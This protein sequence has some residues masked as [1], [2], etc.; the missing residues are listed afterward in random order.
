[1][2]G[3]VK[4]DNRVVVI[5]GP[6]KKVKVT[7]QQVLEALKIDTDELMPYQDSKRV[8]SLLRNELKPG[9]IIRKETDAKVGTTTLFLSNGAKVKYKKTDSKMTKSLWKQ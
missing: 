9:S 1:M 8:T 2:E 3:L 4:E 5:T 7:E 6:E